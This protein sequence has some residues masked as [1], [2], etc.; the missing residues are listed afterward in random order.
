MW[1]RERFEAAEVERA[2]LRAAAKQ[3]G[4]PLTADESEAL[5]QFESELEQEL[6]SEA[7]DRLLYASGD[8]NRVL[9]RWVGHGFPAEAA[10]LAQGDLI[11]RLD[12]LPIYHHEEL[13]WFLEETPPGTPVAIEFQRGETVHQTEMVTGPLPRRHRGVDG[14]DVVPNRAEP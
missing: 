11:L 5:W 10:G 4:R 12:G 7:Y 14:L 8:P 13:R 9:V 6:G 1:L 2:R 3:A